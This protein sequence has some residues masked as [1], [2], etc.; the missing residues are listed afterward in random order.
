MTSFN[1]LALMLDEALKQMQSQSQ[2]NKPGSGSCNKPGGKGSKPSPSAG[3][4]KKMQQSL[5]K[6]L[7]E[8]KKQGKNQGK[9][10]EGGQMSQQLAQMA[11]KQAAIRKAVE[12]KAAELNE[13]GSGNGNEMK[14]IA[15]DMEEIQKDIVN[16]QIDEE[17]LRKQQD[18]EIR[19]LKAEEAER[20]RGQEEK[21]KSNE[22]QDYPTSNPTKYADYIRRKQQE[23]ELLKTVPPSLKPYY[24]EKVNSY[25]NKLGTK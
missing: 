12:E 20:I 22:A 4:M 24:K 21:R 1:N 3:D 18:I 13:D 8:M 11:A 10:G 23:T 7:E 25:F 19:L 9:S 16:N 14:Q 5:A 15:K 6:Q 2:C 17:T